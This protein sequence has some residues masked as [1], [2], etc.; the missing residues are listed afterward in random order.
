MSSAPISTENYYW[1][2]FV[3]TDEDLEFINNHLFELES[4]QTTVELVSALVNLRITKEKD[5][6]K[7]KKQDQGRLYLPKDSYQVKDSVLFSTANWQSAKVVSIR[8]GVNPEY[9]P[10]KVIDVEFQNGDKRSFAAEF[11]DH[12]LNSPQDI[13]A[14]LKHLDHVYVMTQYGQSLTGKL[15]DVLIHDK[16]LVLTAGTWFPRALLVDINIGHLNLAEA[17]LDMAGGGPIT[18]P[19]LM[20]QLDLPDDVNHDLLEFS[21]NFALQE[22]P[23]FDE[24]GPSGEVLWFLE[25]LEPENVRTVP[26]H[27]QYVGEPVDRS[28]FDVQMIRTEIQMDDEYSPK[29]TSSTPQLDEVQLVLTFPHWRA[30][31]LPLSNRTDA[32]FPIALESPRIKFQFI[33]SESKTTIPG[34][35]VRPHKYVVGLRDWYLANNIIPGSVITIHKKNSAGDVVISAN[36]KRPNKEWIRTTLVGAD[37]EVVLALLKQQISTSYEERMATAI[38]DVDAL[39]RVWN[40]TGKQRPG[41]EQTILK[42]ARE[43]TKLNPQ[44]HIHALELYA[45]ANVLRRIPLEVVFYYLANH[46]AFSHVGDLYYRLI[47]GSEQ[48]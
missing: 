41:T 12:I 34:W 20:S 46:I 36:K 17:V 44:G 15:Q 37:E 28:M 27:L 29:D 25:R 18:T 2:N 42:I 38:P 6:L 32:L 13:L 16:D 33:D 48:E 4:P 1:E 40:L 5:F 30:G 11:D 24:V 26:L 43:L 39:D 19:A 35:V 9:S 21:L 45:A 3:V 10:F 31:S 22:D 47:D 8:D 14:G 23:R 7:R